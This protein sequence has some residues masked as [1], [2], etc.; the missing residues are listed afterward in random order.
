MIQS[1]IRIPVG[2]MFAVLGGLL[3]FYGAITLDQPAM[4]PT[5]IPIVLLWGVVMIVFGAL[6][7]WS[8]RRKRA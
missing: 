7:L 2:A 5:G 1:D 8:A 6:M 3:A 4:R